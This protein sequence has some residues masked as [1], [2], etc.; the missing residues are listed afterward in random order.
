LDW[1]KTFWI[2]DFGF[3]IGVKPDGN[4]KSEAVQSHF[5][6]V[7]ALLSEHFKIHLSRLQFKF[8]IKKL[9]DRDGDRWLKGLGWSGWSMGSRSIC[10]DS[11]VTSYQLFLK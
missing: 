8:G 2:L 9:L 3:W 11:D 6:I 7:E 1:C 10:I 5:W 4:Q